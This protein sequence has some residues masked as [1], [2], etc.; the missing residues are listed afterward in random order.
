MAVVMVGMNGN[1]YT[2]MQVSR[3]WC[4]GV[5]PHKWNNVNK[6][7]QGMHSRYLHGHKSIDID[8]EDET[9]VSYAL[10]IRRGLYIV[11]AIRLQQGWLPS[12]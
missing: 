10:N 12:L 5:L 3:E 2:C 9:S 6:M 7:T 1:R 4:A 8:D 11:A